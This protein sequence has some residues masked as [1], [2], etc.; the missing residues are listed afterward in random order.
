MLDRY[1][2]GDTRRIS[3]EAPVPVIEAGEETAR[4]GGAANVANN[5]RALGAVP[6]LVG[7]C[8]TDGFGHDLRS[9]LR[10]SDVDVEGVVLDDD[11]RTTCK[12]RVIARHQQ[13]VRIDREDA[14]E[15]QGAALGQV[16]ERAL[17]FLESS[18]ACVISDYGKGVITPELVD[19]VLQ[20]ARVLGVPVCVDPKETHFFRW[21]GVTTITPNQQEASVAAG[22]K[23]SDIA[24]LV[25]AG[26][27]LL[28]QLESQS[29]LITRGDQGMVLF[30]SDHSPLSFPAIA[31]DV[32][33]V[34]GAGDTV[35]SAFALAVAAGADL[36]EATAISNHAAGLVVR[37]VGTAVCTVDVLRESLGRSPEKWAPTLLEF[38]EPGK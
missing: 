7:V 24:S 14:R 17:A 12:T 25:R 19:P 10:Q 21:R 13:V 35:V 37:E 29:V 30:R 15:L 32:F 36:P 27:T 3:P 28:Q 4:L 20:R 38:A 18:R 23:V 33:D 1:L 22:F 2:W 6:R 11:R 9:L 34:T 26:R 31:R 5:V 8:G 16:R